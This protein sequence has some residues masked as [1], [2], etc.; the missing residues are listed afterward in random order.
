[1]KN[2]ILLI[3]PNLIGIKDGLNRIQPPLGL[4][5]MASTLLKKNY[6]VKILDTALEGWSN[7][8][9][10][11]NDKIYIGMKDHEIEEYIRKY[12]PHIVGISVLFSN[13]VK[14]CH[15]IAKIIKKVDSN[16]K[17]VLGGNHITNSHIDYMHRVVH[18]GDKIPLI[19]DLEDKNIDY[20][21]TGESDFNFLKLVDA[22]IN[23]GDIK[24]VPGILIKESYG[25]YFYISS[26]RISKLDILPKPARHL[27]N[28]EG[29]FD[30]GAFHSAKSRSNRVLSI[31][32]SRG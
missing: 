27:V 14:S 20:A 16:I 17:V 12:K 7:K 3:T 13:L 5:I 11:D 22:I 9:A 1:M 8:V 18:P 31:M 10:I 26:G 28:M 4:M 21:M 32:C 24:V 15:T 29:Y 19:H 25:K 2:R 23:G 30:I 6:E